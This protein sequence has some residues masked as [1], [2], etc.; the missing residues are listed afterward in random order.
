VR[1]SG[2]SAVAFYDIPSSNTQDMFC[3]IIDLD[4]GEFG[5]PYK[6]SVFLHN[7]SRQVRTVKVVLSSS[8]VFY[9]GEKAHLIKKGSGE[10]KMKPDERETLSMEVTASDYMSR[11]VDMCLIKNNVLV[12]VAETDQT[13]TSEDDFVLD[14]PHLEIKVPDSPRIGRVTKIEVNFTNP[15]DVDLTRCS[16]SLEAPGVLRTREANYPTIG[17]GEKVRAVIPIVPRARGKSTLVVIFNSKELT[18]ITGSKNIA[19]L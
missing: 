8:S 11:V 17:P 5:Q 6:V 19:V 10:F 14:K 1:G 18:D 3:Q 7:Q 15:L 13:W 4:K 9:T 2:T 12:T 16:L